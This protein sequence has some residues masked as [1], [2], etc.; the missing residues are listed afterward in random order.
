MELL[1]CTPHPVKIITE[2]DEIVLAPS[3]IIPRVA[4]K[5]TDATTLVTDQGVVPAWRTTYGAVEG[6]PEAVPGRIVIV[7]ALV[8]SASARGDL[9]SPGAFVR[10]LHGQVIGCSGLFLSPSSATS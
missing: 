4:V 2:N 8:V 1:N 6:L 10:D 7:S 3:G 9:A 5:E